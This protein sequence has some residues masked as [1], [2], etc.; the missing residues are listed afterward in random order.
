MEGI[1]QQIV[2]YVNMI[3]KFH[4]FKLACY[5]YYMSCDLIR[6]W[7]LSLSETWYQSNL[8]FCHIINLPPNLLPNPC[9]FWPPIPCFGVFN[10]RLVAGY[11]VEES[12]SFRLYRGKNVFCCIHFG[13][14]NQILAEISQDHLRRGWFFAVFFS[15][16]LTRST[17][18]THFKRAREQF[19]NLR[20]AGRCC[21]VHYRIWETY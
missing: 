17:S 18:R 12:W 10:L 1:R 21:N 19:P 7:I 20:H 11:S 8:N 14:S 15:L 16:P 13:W 2:M 6:Q 4:M 5:L 9:V 3:Q